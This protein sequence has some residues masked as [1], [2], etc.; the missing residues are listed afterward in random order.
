LNL[1]ALEA[2]A[3]LPDETNPPASSSR[4]RLDR[5]KKLIF[6]VQDDGTIVCLKDGVKHTWPPS[7]PKETVSEAAGPGE[8]RATDAIP[9]KAESSERSTLDDA[10]EGNDS[11]V[12]DEDASLAA[13]V[14]NHDAN[15]LVTGP[16]NDAAERT[17][18]RRRS[19][20]MTVMEED[21]LARDCARASQCD[22]EVC[23]FAK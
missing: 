11:E 17:T 12:D 18:G 15:P 19:S 21:R 8:H 20:E 13:D 23:D 22:P 7:P 16:D 5:L 3:D 4:E 6:R 9:S 10:V 1:S 2:E 14:P